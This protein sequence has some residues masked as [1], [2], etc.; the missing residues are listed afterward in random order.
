MEFPI[1]RCV[2][3]ALLLTACGAI[4][5]IAW[6]QCARG[7]QYEQLDAV[8]RRYPDP[9]VRF[10]TPAFAPG[11]VGFTSYEQMLSY[12]RGLSERATNMLVSTAGHSQEGRSVPLLL[13]TNSGRLAPPELRRVERPLVLIVGQAHG[14]EPAGG[15]ALLALAQSLAVGELRPLLDRISVAIMPRVN[16]DGAHYFWR[17]TT[18][19]VDVNR[20]HL[21]VDLPE[22]I[23]IRRATLELRPEVFIDAHEFS[24]A[25][26]WIEK[27]NAVQAYDLT[28]AYATHPNVDSRLTEM[29]ERV[30][31]RNIA[32][33]VASAGYSH[34]WYYTTAYSV[35]DKKRL[36]DSRVRDPTP[37]SCCPRTR[38]SRG[39][40]PIRV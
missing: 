31:S 17:S 23:A 32:R 2:A 9:P 28:T 21:K 5:P 6:A 13:F 26:R 16:P 27:F 29:A 37:T 30:F 35:K 7:A 19:C 33:D 18:S 15:E 20:D 25:T 1:K 11:A 3:A 39:G 40:S 36:R 12:V 4:S 14:N 10:D 8:K 24:V 38:K 34:F 22:T